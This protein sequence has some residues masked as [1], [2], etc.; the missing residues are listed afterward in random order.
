MVTIDELFLRQRLALL[1]TEKGISARELSL[2]LGQ[3]EGYINA[4]E[5]GRS[6]P[7]ITMLFYICEEL[8]VSL[9]AFFD[10]GAR[11]PVLLEEILQEGKRLNRDA[12]ESV[13]N[14]MKNM[15]S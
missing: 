3:S 8:G 1:R 12:L 4:I 7:S 5:T 6:M 14:I 13:L 9:S 15:Q 11:N 2:R 10:E